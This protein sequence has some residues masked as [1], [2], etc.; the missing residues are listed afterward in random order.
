MTRD[1]RAR[2]LRII[3]GIDRITL[4]GDGCGG[5]TRLVYRVRLGSK[6]ALIDRS[7]KV[8][9]G[10]VTDEELLELA[11]S[12]MSD[13]SQFILDDKEGEENEH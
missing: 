7:G 9:S 13:L 5:A 3:S 6:T 4:T 1:E 8:L 10:S 12:V 2:L 11:M